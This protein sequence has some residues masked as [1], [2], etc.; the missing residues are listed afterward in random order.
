M[1]DGKGASLRIFVTDCRCHYLY[2]AN[3]GNARTTANFRTIGVFVVN[4]E[5]I[6]QMAHCSAVWIVDFEQVNNAGWE[7]SNLFQYLAAICTKWYRA[8]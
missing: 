6:S 4:F 8:Q 3:N 5:Q 7:Y 2:R 1:R